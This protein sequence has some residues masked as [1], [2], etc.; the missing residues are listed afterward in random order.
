MIWL[1]P[2]G[3]Q[4]ARLIQQSTLSRYRVETGLLNLAGH[5]ILLLACVN[6]LETS[7]CI[8]LLAS[9]YNTVHSNNKH[10]GQL[11]PQ[12]KSSK[13]FG[14][15][16]RRRSLGIQQFITTWGT[17]AP[18]LAQTRL[19]AGDIYLAIKTRGIADRE[20]RWA[21]HLWNHLEA[22]T[23]F[24]FATNNLLRSSFNRD[25]LMVTFSPDIESSEIDWNV[26][27]NGSLQHIMSCIYE[28]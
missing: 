4:P 23:P 12:A 10:V 19:R 26:Q 20:A 15:P 9:A 24:V 17:L 16:S 2:S 18:W 22:I 1:T 25:V 28:I 27:R 7:Y 21:S 8:W 6:C 11:S 5:Y 3:I 13:Q 14:L